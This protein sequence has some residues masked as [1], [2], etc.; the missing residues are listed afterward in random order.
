[1][2][3][4]RFFF[5]SRDNTILSREECSHAD[6]SAAIAYAKAKNSIQEIEIWESHRCVGVVPAFVPST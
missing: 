3:M 2:A 5:L 1:M 6:N 4:Y